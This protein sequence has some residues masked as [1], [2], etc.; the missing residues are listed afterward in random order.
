MREEVGAAQLLRQ[1][2]YQAAA[3]RQREGRPTPARCDREREEIQRQPRVAGAG[4]AGRKAARRRQAVA[5]DSSKPSE[6][7]LAAIAGQVPG[8]S[9]RV[10]CLNSDTSPVDTATDDSSA[11]QAQRRGCAGTCQAR[12]VAINTHNAPSWLSHLPAPWI[13]WLVDQA[14]CRAQWL[15]SSRYSRSANQKSPP[16]PTSHA[17]TISS[18]A[19]GR[20]RWVANG[21]SIARRRPGEASVS[22][23]AEGTFMGSRH[24]ESAAMIGSELSESGRTARLRSRFVQSSLSSVASAEGGAPASHA[25]R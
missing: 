19:S 11:N 24:T 7:T 10:T 5:R 20:Y 4:M 16:P 6:G 25:L 13:S 23:D 8:Q 17:L 18:S 21:A 22:T 1:A 3:Q 9:M 12:S 15:P 14:C 2:E